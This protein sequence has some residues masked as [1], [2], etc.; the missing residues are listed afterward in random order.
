MGATG[1]LQPDPMPAP[2]RV[3][4]RPQIKLDR[5]GCARCSIGETD[6]PIRDVDR[7]AALGDVAETGMQEPVPL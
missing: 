7:L 6:D 5:M 4:N 1:D 3:R 2:E